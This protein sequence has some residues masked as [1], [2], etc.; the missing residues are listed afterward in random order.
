MLL[1]R[2][3]SK[4][5]LR[6]F[7]RSE[8]QEPSKRAVRTDQVRLVIRLEQ[9]HPPIAASE[10]L[11]KH[12]ESAAALRPESSY[13]AEHR[14]ASQRCAPHTP[15][16]ASMPIPRVRALRQQP[17]ER[18]EVHPVLQFAA[19]RAA[20]ATTSGSGSCS[21]LCRTLVSASPRTATAIAASTRRF[22]SSDAAASAIHSFV[23]SG[24]E[25]SGCAAKAAKRA[26]GHQLIRMTEQPLRQI[27]CIGRNPE[28]IFHRGLHH[29]A[30]SPKRDDRSSASALV[31]QGPE[32]ALLREL[33]HF[34]A[35][36]RELAVDKLSNCAPADI[37]APRPAAKG[38]HSLPRIVR[39]VVSS[40]SRIVPASLTLIAQAVQIQPAGGQA[41][42][43]GG[44]VLVLRPKRKKDPD[45]RVSEHRQRELRHRRFKML[46]KISRIAADAA[47]KAVHE[48]IGKRFGTVAQFERQRK[49]K[50]FHTGPVE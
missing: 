12:A 6:A 13:R 36:L 23:I 37:H 34:A 44:D 25:A 29:G 18:I 11:S 40:S 28:R 31:V 50:Q 16:S 1:Y 41:L 48:D 15:A 21:S 8:I 22:L 3:A 9:T 33:I 5:Q 45:E 38:I 43:N 24:S 17:Q 47:G 32:P 35:N 42:A 19:V 4:I 30:S 49:I 46:V 20:S 27:R 2:F 14:R 10:C 7:S 26:A 39:S